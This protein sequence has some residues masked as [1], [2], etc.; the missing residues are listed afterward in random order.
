MVWKNS[1]W[2]RLCHDAILASAM[3]FG[4]KLKTTWFWN[5][6]CIALGKTH[7]IGTLSIDAIARC[8][9]CQSSAKHILEYCVLG[10]SGNSRVGFHCDIGTSAMFFGIKVK[11]TWFWY[12]CISA[13]W[14]THV[15]GT[16]M[17]Q[18]WRSAMFCESKV[19]TNM[20]LD[21][22]FWCVSETPWLRDFVMCY[23]RRFGIKL[24]HI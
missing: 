6:G 8:D 11:Q 4:I 15:I 19:K 21:I 16:F 13:L 22:L 3:F 7:V 23:C 1:P 18:Y 17:M 20:I 24:T 9:F 2:F 10:V 12:W 5:I 14:K